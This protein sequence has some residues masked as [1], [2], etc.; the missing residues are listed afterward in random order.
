MP[1]NY[2]LSGQCLAIINTRLQNL[3]EAKIERETQWG[4]ADTFIQ[5]NAERGH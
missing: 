2:I 3:G 4:T 1:Q 5:I